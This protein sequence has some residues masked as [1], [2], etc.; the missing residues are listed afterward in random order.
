MTG[1][2]SVFPVCSQLGSQFNSLRICVFLVFLQIYIRTCETT[3]LIPICIFLGMLQSALNT[4]N[5]GNT[6]NTS[7]STGPA[8]QCARWAV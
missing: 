6:R 4:G 7:W 2:P 5:S 3:Y 8:F 1:V